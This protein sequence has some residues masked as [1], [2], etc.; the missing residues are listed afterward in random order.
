M[1]EA[2]HDENLLIVVGVVFQAAA[3]WAA[4]VSVQ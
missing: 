2:L 3:Q 4:A 1:I